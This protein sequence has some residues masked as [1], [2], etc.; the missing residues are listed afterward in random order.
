MDPMH[1]LQPYNLL[2]VQQGFDIFDEIVSPLKKVYN[3]N[4]SL[5][6]KYFLWYSKLLKLDETNTGVTGVYK[7][8]FYNSFPPPPSKNFNKNISFVLKIY[9]A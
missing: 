5:I 3:K 9:T 7:F 6:F 1:S 8:N 2:L 4:I